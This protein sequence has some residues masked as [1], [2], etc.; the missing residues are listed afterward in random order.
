M[1]SLHILSLLSFLLSIPLLGDMT[2]GG[3][4]SE[5]EEV[6]GFVFTIDQLVSSPPTT[7][8]WHVGL[9]G[10]W[11]FSSLQCLGMA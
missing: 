5:A 11:P 4:G 7:A 1:L 8:H 9:S 10:P 3:G 2:D 6:L